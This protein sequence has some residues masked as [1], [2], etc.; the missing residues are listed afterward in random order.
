MIERLLTPGSILELAM[1]RFA[2]GKYIL[3]LFPIGAEQSYT[4]CNEPADEI[5][6]NRALQ[7]AALCVLVCIDIRMNE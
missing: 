3:R 4:R 1:R 6:A 5:L 2:F 7:K